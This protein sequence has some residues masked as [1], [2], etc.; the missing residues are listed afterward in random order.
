MG[1]HLTSPHIHG[2]EN[3][4]DDDLKDVLHDVDLVDDGAALERHADLI[5]RAHARKGLGGRLWVSH[6]VN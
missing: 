1:I 3:D 2:E 4:D 5:A 6:V